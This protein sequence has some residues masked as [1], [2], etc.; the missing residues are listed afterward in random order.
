MDEKVEIRPSPNGGHNWHP[1]AFSPKT[2]LV[3]IPANEE[4]FSFSPDNKFKNAPMGMNLGIDLTSVTLPAGG[5]ARRDALAKEKGFLLAWDPVAQKEIWRAPHDGP[6]NGGVLTTAGNLVFQGTADGDFNAYRADTG[7]KLWSMPVQTGVIAGPMSYEVGGGQYIA[8]L[9]GF[10][11]GY[12][13]LGGG[14]PPYERRNISRVLAFKLDGKASLPPLSTQT[15]LV[16]DPPPQTAGAA[17]VAKG[18]HLYS[19]YCITCHGIDA[20]SGGLVPDLRR[21]GLLG[22]NG[23]FSVVLGGALQKQGMVSF[24]KVLDH[25]KAS[26]IRAYVI[27]QAIDAR[28]AMAQNATTGGDRESAQ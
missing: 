13:L 8:L 10:G 15:A 5:T 1:M 24:A 3:Y 4:S 23:W 22:N 21:S 25:P 28:A 7:E 20:V 6:W 27:G 17:T 16:L 12:A 2:A 18:R 14:L 9:V 26:A 19:R 11:G